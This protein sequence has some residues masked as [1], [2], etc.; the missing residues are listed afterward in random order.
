MRMH[1]WLLATLLAAPLYFS[2]SNSDAQSTANPSTNTIEAQPVTPLITKRLDLRPPK[3][4]EVFS[5]ATIDQ[6][7]RSTPDTRT[8]EEIEVEGR[9]DAIPPRTPDIWPGPFSIFWAMF[10]P[11]QSWRILLPLPPDQAAQ[12]SGPP[13]SATDPYRPVM[14]GPAFTN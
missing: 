10:N 5:Q 9:R 3:V 13:P 12:F 8:L 1:H 4:T 11:S 14:R 7:L 2:S 6:A